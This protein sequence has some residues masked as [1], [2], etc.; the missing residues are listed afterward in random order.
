MMNIQ[1]IEARQENGPHDRS[2]AGN[3]S[4]VRGL[5]TQNMKKYNLLFWSF[6]AFI[7]YK[8]II[9][10]DHG[11]ASI[12]IIIALFLFI[13]FGIQIFLINQLH[14]DENKIMIFRIST[15]DENV[16][17]II[18]QKLIIILVFKRYFF[19]SYFVWIF[20]RLI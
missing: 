10:L 5:S 14:N 7:Y 18:I 19:K 15:L 4:G 13:N 12:S 8:A 6:G 17:K 1:D 11:N 9:N 20:R 2:G 16:F 3:V